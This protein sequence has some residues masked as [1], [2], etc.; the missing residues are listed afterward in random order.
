MHR[1]LL[2][3]TNAVAAALF[4]LLVVTTAHAATTAPL[5]QQDPKKHHL[6]V[7]NKGH[8]YTVGYIELD[9]V[10]SYTWASEKAYEDFNDMKFGVRIH[11]GLY[12]MVE[13][14]QE[15]WP[16]LNL[17]HP[18]KQKH[19]DL[20][21]QWNP[22]NFDAQAWMQLFVD[23]GMKMFAFTTKHHEGFSL[24]DTKTRVKKRVRWDAPGGPVM[25]DCDFAYSVMDTP[26]KRDIV[27]ELVDAARQHD[28]KINLYY[29]HNDWYD[30]DFRPYLWH[31]LQVPSSAKL[32][33]KGKDLV[34]EGTERF[35]TTPPVY[36]PDP[37]PEEVDRMMKRHHDQ[38]AELLTNYGKIDM[39]CL[40]GQFGPAVWPKLRQ[41]MHDLRKIQPDVMFRARGIGNYGDYY[42]P[43][44][45]V[46]GAKENTHVPW[47]VIYPLGRSFS[48][49][50]VPAQ[51][52]GTKW[53][54]ENLLDCAAKGGG[55]MVGIGPDGSGKFHET[56]ITQLRQ[57]G[58]WLK[59]HGES[60][61][62]TRARPGNDWKEG[63][64]I[65][66]TQTKDHQTLYAHCFDWPG[67]QLVLKTVKA[68]PRS[69]IV[70]LGDPEAAP[71]QWKNNP[72]QGLVI[73]LPDALLSRIPE[74]QRF[75]H[76]FKIAVE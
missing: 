23:S 32:S 65:R 10:P 49:E 76:T 54:V 6:P 47:F 43:E 28:L 64:R 2:S 60:V 63:D 70:L 42:T 52:K 58:R 29:S 26:S 16:L 61:Y 13:W 25:E 48:Y 51:H 33:V 75:A 73:T 40:D 34:Y 38:L 41:T 1:S 19:F 3:L 4:T 72:E 17:P 53:I 15:S 74:D 11:W 8:I 55:F 31:P 46:P 39:I 69:R 57:T 22:Q 68:K 12:S 36:V 14:T 56:A 30:A 37:T 9:A 66:F 18:E 24:Y 35:K 21:K 62:K 45:F 7:T 50:N 67:Q 27:R 20:Y 71:L 5:D 59:V 44:G